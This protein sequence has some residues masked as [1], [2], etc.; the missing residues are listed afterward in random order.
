MDQI[1]QLLL[2]IL[3]AACVFAGI[4]WSFAQ[5]Y[6]QRGW[7]RIAY[8][9][10]AFLT[11][12]IMASMAQGWTAIPMLMSIPLMGSSLLAAYLDKGWNMVLPFLIFFFALAV[13][14]GLPFVAV[15]NAAPVA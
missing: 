13:S 10:T 1:V 8:T 2:G 4:V 14:L 9:M 15:A 3:I 12:V 6:R 7:I 5:M 11:L